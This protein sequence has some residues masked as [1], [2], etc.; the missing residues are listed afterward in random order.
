MEYRTVNDE[1]TLE[2]K[3]GRDLFVHGITKVIQSCDP[4][5]V[6]GMY[7]SWGVG[8]TSLMKLINGK[9]LN[10]VETGSTLIKT[11]WFD[12]WFHQFDDNLAVA[13][14]HCISKEAGSRTDD[15]KKILTTIGITLGSVLFKSLTTLDISD[16]KNIGNTYENERFQV[17]ELQ[18]QLKENLDE[19]INITTEQGKYTLVIFIDDLD[20][21]M[22]KQALSVLESLKLYF[23]NE[24]CVYVLGM[25]RKV[26]EASIQDQY[27][28]LELNADDYLDK[29]IQ[30]PFNIPP[31]KTESIVGFVDELLPDDLE[32]ASSIL[33]E[34]LDDNPRNL[35]R[36]INSFVLQSAFA[37]EILGDKF[38]CSIMAGVLLIQHKEPKIFLELIED[39]SLFKKYTGTG[40]SEKSEDGLGLS[41]NLAIALRL[42]NLSMDDD[43]SKYIHLTEATSIIKNLYDVELINCGRNKTEIQETIKD[44]TG[45]S[46]AEAKELI[47]RQPSIIAKSQNKKDAGFLVKSLMEHG[48]TAKVK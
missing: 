12:P 47:S 43:I 20:R 4:P 44:Q 45:I 8:K 27:S 42:I 41:P 48:A 13:L 29:I 33:G 37:K 26:L 11:V 2:D 35:K 31:I 23:N 39:S 14:L 40:L 1:P 16:V 22:P 10:E 32:R 19:L 38:D 7:G 17:R 5:F 24:N 36:F 15:V 6:I 25:D 3:L 21:C 34:G 28:A 18:I 9:L 46:S 30:L